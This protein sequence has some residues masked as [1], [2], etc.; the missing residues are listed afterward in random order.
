MVR[1]Q[2]LAP[3]AIGRVLVLEWTGGQFTFRLL[4]GLGL[5]QGLLFDYP[6]QTG[7]QGIQLVVQEFTVRLLISR[8]ISGFDRLTSRRSLDVSRCPRNAE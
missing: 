8:S 5:R 4:L 6:S 2:D 7:V 1:N 3:R